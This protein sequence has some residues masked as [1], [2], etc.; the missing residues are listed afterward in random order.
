MLIRYDVARTRSITKNNLKMTNSLETRMVLHFVTFLLCLFLN[1]SLS[2]PGHLSDSGSSRC[3][4]SSRAQRLVPSG[5]YGL[6]VR[7]YKAGKQ[8]DLGSN[9][10]RFSF[11]FKTCG[12][13]TLSCDFVPHN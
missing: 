11:L 8:R 10:L 2:L 6:A 13:R 3:S 12:L 5:K 7:R 1:L 9:P 4:H